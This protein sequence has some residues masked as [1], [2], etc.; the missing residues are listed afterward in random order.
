MDDVAIQA[1]ANGPYKITGPVTIVDSEGREFD[2][3]E[4]NAVALCRC[5]YSAN[6][7]F[8][9]ASHKRVGFVAEDS[10]PRVS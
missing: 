3:P 6:K 8:C 10:A 5:G 4:G 9:D 1:R 2:I 7:P